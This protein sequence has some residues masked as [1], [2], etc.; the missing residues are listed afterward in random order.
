M[1]IPILDIYIY[2][3]DINI[4]IRYIDFHIYS[5]PIFGLIIMAVLF[6]HVLCLWST[7]PLYNLGPAQ[8]ACVCCIIVISFQ[9]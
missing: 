4:Y 9:I 1:Q 3:L 8:V 5:M 6:P 2:I 7:L